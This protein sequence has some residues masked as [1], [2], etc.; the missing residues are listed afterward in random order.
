MNHIE[1]EVRSFI[2][3]TQY[4]KLEEKLSKSAKFLKEI[5]EETIYCG[6]ENLRIRRD[7]NFS[8]LIFKT[9]KIHDDSREEI[10]IKFKRSKFEEL[11]ELFGALGFKINVIWFRKRKVYDWEGTKVFLDG[12]KGYGKIIEL[13]EIGTKKDK[14]KIK[15]K[16]KEKLKCLGIKITPKKIFDKK[17]ENY[18]KNWRKIYEISTNNWPRNTR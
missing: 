14:E 2:S 16:L 13:E 7:R 12:T 1:V 17:F 11:K 4:K 6:K 9:G 18:K 15:K 10:K 3:P 8:Y 5:N